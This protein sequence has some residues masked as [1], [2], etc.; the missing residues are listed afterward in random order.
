MAEESRDEKDQDSEKR[1]EPK[2]WPGTFLNGT[3][4]V[5]VAAAPSRFSEASVTQQGR[6]IDRLAKLAVFRI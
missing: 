2:P 4:G 1:P 3:L 5:L 6:P